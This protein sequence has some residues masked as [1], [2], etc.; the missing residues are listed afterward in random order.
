VDMKF[1]SFMLF[2]SLFLSTPVLRATY[3]TAP[4]LD[5]SF[6]NPYYKPKTPTSAALTK[7][8]ANS[9]LESIKSKLILKGNLIDFSQI[10]KALERFKFDVSKELLS[11]RLLDQHAESYTYSSIDIKNDLAL[12]FLNYFLITP[13]ITTKDFI[14][15]S[16][17]LATYPDSTALLLST[18]LSRISSDE[19][20]FERPIISSFSRKDSTSV[21]I[22]KLVNTF[23]QLIG[24]PDDS[25]NISKSSELNYKNAK[26]A[27]DSWVKKWIA[28]FGMDR[29]RCYQ[30]TKTLLE[31]VVARRT[32][33]YDENTI[34]IKTN[35]AL[36]YVAYFLANTLES[37]AF[38]RIPHSPE[39]YHD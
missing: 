34:E 28:S 7:I 13:K 17:D 32:I 24:R 39:E 36:N 9:L 4:Q 26:K 37:E 1:F 12:G 16:K 14:E 15:P 6:Y 33:A 22:D 21:L 3:T 30:E 2:T 35:L 27:L 29:S 11:N 38:I 10:R 18:S 20:A 8:E 19:A 31:E 23:S 5:L 25:L